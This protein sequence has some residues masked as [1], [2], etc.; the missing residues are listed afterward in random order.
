MHPVPH[1]CVGDPVVPAGAMLAMRGVAF[2]CIPLDERWS[3][4]HVM[5]EAKSITVALITVAA[6]RARDDFRFE[7]RCRVALG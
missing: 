3:V 6:A 5:F 4:A 7:G 1:R 2:I